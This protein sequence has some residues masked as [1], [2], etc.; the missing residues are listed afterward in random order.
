MPIAELRFL[1][2]DEILRLTEDYL[3]KAQLYGFDI[4]TENDKFLKQVTGEVSPASVRLRELLKWYR[5][6]Y[7][8]VLTRRANR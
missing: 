1:D 4:F 7:K 2:D 5:G 6:D 3:G 8:Q